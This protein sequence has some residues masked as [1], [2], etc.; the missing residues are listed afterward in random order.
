MRLRP[1][2]LVTGMMPATIGILMPASSQRARQSWNAL[3][4]KKSCVTM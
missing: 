3:L 4:S 1:L 2:P